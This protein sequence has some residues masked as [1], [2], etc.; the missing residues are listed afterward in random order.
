[1]RTSHI[2]KLSLICLIVIG[3]FFAVAGVYAQSEPTG[4][5]TLT[6]EAIVSYASAIIVNADNSIDVTETITYN[7]GP[8]AHHGIYRD[9]YPHSS[10]KFKMDIEDIMV[11]DESGNQYMFDVFDFQGFVRVKIGDPDVTFVGQKTYIIHYRARNAVA[12]F[13]YYDE[14]YWNATGNG[15]TMPILQAKATITLPA[16][17]K[18]IQSYCYYGF[19]GST[20][21][22][23]KSQNS[24]QTVEFNAP[25]PL[26]PEEG[27]TVAVGFEKGFVT[28]YTLVDK[29]KNGIF[30][31]LPW[32]I[33]LLLPLL[34]LI[35]SLW[36]WFKFGRS[37]K[38]TGVIVPQYDVPDNLAPMEVAGIASLGIS[39]KDISAEIIH[40]AILG[41]VKI[42]QIE[43]KTLGIFKST[44]YELIK[45][46]DFNDLPNEFDKK[47]LETLFSPNKTSVLLSYFKEPQNSI[48]EEIM[49]VLT[50][51]SD[52]LLKKEY[53]KKRNGMR[54]YSPGLWKFIAL[55][56]T[57]FAALGIIIKIFSV[58]MTVWQIFTGIVI[59]LVIYT[60]IAICGSIRT[61][62]SIRA[63]EYILGLKDYLQ[64]AEKDRLEFHNAPEKKPEI[65]EKF[66]PYAMVLGVADIWAKEFDGIYMTPPSWYG[67]GSMD[68]FNAS[69][70]AHSLS[71][72]STSASTATAGSS[73]GSGGGGSSGGGGGGGGGG[74]W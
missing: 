25:Y 2:L 24:S 49:A 74:S 51:A 68:G 71:G 55:S 56:L 44:D 32:L 19:M 61:E 60:V 5:L 17:G 1:M 13:T 73:G 31:Y 48:H 43:K 9:I 38:G 8:G 26:N 6:S 14:I 10:A 57:G 37:P 22:C 11:T 18:I 59:S 29:L 21:T 54:K 72:F 42:N 15:W 64:I 41:Y 47:L 63:K 65:F 62:K 20:N 36:H 58:D 4:E 66:L 53:Y 40:L 46:K 35:F 23:Q 33:L 34:T 50:S 45:L 12:Q 16:I 28:A 30:I 39:T 67:G 52:S 69:V 7:T 27:L 3:S 70:L